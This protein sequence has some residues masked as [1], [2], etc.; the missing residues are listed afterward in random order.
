MYSRLYNLWFIDHRARLHLYVASGVVA[1][2]YGVAN[3][4]LLGRSERQVTWETLEL[5]CVSVLGFTIV[6]CTR[7]EWKAVERRWV[8]SKKG[9][10]MLVFVG[11][12]VLILST[13]IPRSP[14]L[15]YHEI[16]PKLSDIRATI[17]TAE[18]QRT[19]LP[20]SQIAQFKKTIVAT[21][22]SVADYWTTM[23]A[24]INYQSLV[25]QMRGEAPDPAA[26]SSRCLGFTSGGNVLS[27]NN[28]FSGG[29]VSNCVVDLDEEQFHNITFHNSVIRYHG[30]PVILE[31]VKFVNCRFV[32]ELSAKPE[33]PAKQ[34]LLI[35]LLGSR[36]Q[37]NV[38]IKN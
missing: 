4:L 7:D 32:L 26:V 31:N 6:Y 12:T 33:S 36:D 25:N 13:L 17:N 30:G 16:P 38:E 22:P 19:I 24:V 21:S 34:N 3:N 28:S 23:A 11:A 9:R 14:L 15:F 37:K 5:L 10:L 29:D 18:T 8:A 20:P 35:A 2:L 27:Y 1:F